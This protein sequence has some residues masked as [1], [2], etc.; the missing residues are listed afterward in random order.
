M[1]TW[2]PSIAPPSCF[3]IGANAVSPPIPESM[4]R[5]SGGDVVVEAGRV[6]GHQDPIASIALVAIG[7]HSVDQTGKVASSHSDW[8]HASIFLMPEGNAVTSSSHRS[9]SRTASVTAARSL[10]STLGS[11]LAA[12][13]CL[14]RFFARSQLTGPPL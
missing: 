9:A 4:A 1:P 12:M 3:S 2:L 6:K 8:D 10:A 13:E 11:P 5:I 7:S 14:A